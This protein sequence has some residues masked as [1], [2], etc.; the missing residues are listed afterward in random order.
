[1]KFLLIDRKKWIKLKIL[2]LSLLMFLSLSIFIHPL[3]AKEEKNKKIIRV[4][5]K[6]GQTLDL[7]AK[8]VDENGKTVYLKDLISVP[9]IIT[10]VYLMCPNV[11]NIQL[12]ALAAALAKLDLVPLKD[13]RV[14]TISFS[15]R[16]KFPLAKEKQN[17][18]LAAI[19]KDFPPDAWKFLVGDRDNIKKFVDSIGFKYIKQGEMD[20]LHPVTIVFVTKDGK[21]VRYLYGTNIL[22]FDLTLAINE[23]GKGHVG[24]SI[25]RRVLDYCF[26]FDEKS[27]KYSINILRISAV[28][29]LV[30]IVIIFLVLMFGGKKRS[31][32]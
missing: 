15:E 13:Y 1:M 20:F 16:E 5:E 24:S 14:I 8:F 21:I 7:S 10:P 19:N 23:A 11:C 31:R 29:I 28:V 3:Y 9:T 30:F 6:L 18:Y 22:P 27:N 4:D 12:S 26:T 25:K 17:N 2:V 32:K